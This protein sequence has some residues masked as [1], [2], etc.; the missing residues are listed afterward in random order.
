MGLF[1]R[2]KDAQQQAQ[3]AMQQAGGAGADAGGIS[4]VALSAPLTTA[5]PLLGRIRL[6]TLHLLCLGAGL[7][8]SVVLV[9]RGALSRSAP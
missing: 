2:M 8:G 9:I 3:D 4:T 6:G 1:D 7:V 5:N